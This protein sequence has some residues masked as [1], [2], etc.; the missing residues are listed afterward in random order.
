M[1]QQIIL[2]PKSNQKNLTKRRTT[3]CKGLTTCLKSMLLPLLVSLSIMG[4]TQSKFSQYKFHNSFG[5]YLTGDAGM[6][7]T[8]FSFLGNSEYRFN[9]N[10]GVSGHVQYFKANDPYYKIEVQAW[11]FGL[12]GHA[13][14]G[15]RK[16]FYIGLGIAYERMVESGNYPSYDLMDRSIFLPA[17]RFGRHIEFGRFIFSPEIVLTGPYYETYANGS[18]LEIFTLPSIGVRVHFK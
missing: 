6:Y 8:G 13:Y 12:L 15:K 3:L 9:D 4:Y 14:L 18:S 16:K 17:Y 7:Y 1:K 5:V 11:S 2:N 10:Y